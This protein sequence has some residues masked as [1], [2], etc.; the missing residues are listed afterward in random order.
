MSSRINT[1][2]AQKDIIYN[3]VVNDAMSKYQ[4]LYTNETFFHDIDAINNLSG[5]ER[6]NAIRRMHHDFLDMYVN[7][8]PGSV[9]LI[10]I[11]DKQGQLIG[12]YVN[13]EL[14]PSSFNSSFHIIYT[15]K[16]I[17]RFT[18]DSKDI[19]VI[20][21]RKLQHNNEVY[22]YIEFG[23]TADS[24]L[25]HMESLYSSSYIF[26]IKNTYIEKGGIEDIYGQ[27]INKY[28]V[29]T[30]N[31]YYISDIILQAIVNNIDY[32]AY[33]RKD[34][35][36]II[37]DIYI[38]G[39]RYWGVFSSI[40]DI[41][42]NEL[43][44][45]AEIMPNNYIYQLKNIAFFLWFLTTVALWLFA[46]IVIV[47]ERNKHS[48]MQFNRVL[49]G[50]KMAVD[51]SSLII[52][53]SSNLVINNVNQ[54]F[55][56][57]M[58]GSVDE[59]LGET[60][61][62]FAKR[63]S[64][65]KKYINSFNIENNNKTVFHGIYE[66][67]TKYGK[68]AVL[69]ISSTPIMNSYGDIINILCVMSD[70]TP[71]YSAIKE[72][73]VVED[74]NEEFITILTD[75]IN[76]T[77]NLLVV[78]KKDFTLEYSNSLHLADPND[79][80]ANCYKHNV[81]KCT[82]S[83]DECYVK[84]VF[85]EKM[86]VSYEVIEEEHNIY[87]LI[88][89]FPIL[90]KRGNVWLVVCEHR[91]IFDKVESQKTLIES[92][93][94][95]HAMV[96]QLQEMV[97]ARDIAKSEAEYASKAKSL[98]LANMSHEIR[99]PINGILGFLALLKDCSMDE[100][101]REYLK[102]INSSS[103]SLLSVINDILDFS[104][105]E[106]G[107]MDI[108]YVPFNIVEDIE[109][110]ADMYMARAEEKKI[111]LTIYTD[112]HLP[113]QVLGD[114]VKIKQIMTNLLSNAIKF[115]PEEGCVSL[116]IR[117]IY[118]ENGIARVKFSV[119]DN[120]IGINKDIKE[121]IFDPFAQGDTSITRRFGGTGLGLSISHSMLEMMDSKL[122]LETIENQGS[123][124]SFELS[125]KIM[126][127]K[128]YIT[129]YKIGS[130]ILFFDIQSNCSRVVEEYMSA[131]NIKTTNCHG[132]YSK[133]TKDTDLV[134]IDS[135]KDIER[136][137]EIFS[138]MPYKDKIK[139]IVGTYSIYKNEINKIDGISYIV[140][141]PITLARIQNMFIKLMKKNNKEDNKIADT[142]SKVTLTGDIL[143]VEDNPVNQKLIV[144]FLEK[145]GFTVTVTNNGKE[146]IDTISSGKKFDIIFMDIHMP[147]MDGVAA[148]KE[149][150]AMGIKTPIIALTANV[151]KEDIENFIASGMN[152]HIAKPINFNKINEVLHQYLKA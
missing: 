132:D 40:Y 10:R 15:T 27:N 121:K 92:N 68:K 107:K 100:T 88:S 128:D 138:K 82:K 109:V 59:Y 37:K 75:Y 140:L 4:I 32:A 80:I 105:I 87:E 20:I 54:K 14:D 137:K 125:L 24:F 133:I 25:N 152:N 126:N 47:M 147:V 79:N 5:K 46:F 130:K 48:I 16:E 65:P 8:I 108:E 90:D 81:G 111:E 142:D 73:K 66:W 7:F 78:Y 69:S 145:A 151:I 150:R 123:T 6:E 122:E 49:E 141:K 116:D 136:F 30:G 124:F 21:P 61:T 9:N 72:L 3:N 17:R 89:F 57:L 91:N 83:C 114:S 93:E 45:V 84:Q 26:L 113:Q 70:L 53:F 58:G 118:K 148:T 35:K 134:L 98:F 29:M 11:Y 86:T 143:V 94:K 129:N 33:S 97:H 149:I 144:I 95:E 18:I 50:Y 51:S 106:T 38:D 131:L 44:Y 103:E 96:S 60:I 2:N 1:I 13:G 34:V 12:R 117:S 43:G 31:H 56:D 127:D 67:T 19:A 42:D 28:K 112:P 102:I 104:K 85:E 63:C 77:G 76:A 23:M 55:L 99:T 110:V 41:D 52:E 36:K 71:E 139:Y 22:G 120:G 62:H 135:G 39:V 146:A 64:E 115:T 101:A 119:T 74:K